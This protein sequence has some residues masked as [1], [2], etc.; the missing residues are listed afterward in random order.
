MTTITNEA[1]TSVQWLDEN[2][3]DWYADRIDHAEF[4]RRARVIWTGV[5]RSGEVVHEAVLALI[6]KAGAF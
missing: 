2:I 6:R 5:A 3:A 1:R 4:K